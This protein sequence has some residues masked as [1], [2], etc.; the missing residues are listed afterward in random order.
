MRGDHNGRSVMRLQLVENAFDGCGVVVIEVGRGLVS[1]DE[2]RQFHDRA[3]DCDTLAL[4]AAELPW[5]QISAGP[6]IGNFQRA[7]HSPKTL[8]RVQFGLR[9]L[10]R[11]FDILGGT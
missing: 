2:S 11:E 8:A 3:S 1:Q 4:A 7:M 6:E 10:Q 9:K 5:S